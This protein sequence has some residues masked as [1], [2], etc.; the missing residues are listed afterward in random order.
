MVY[1]VTHKLVHVMERDV[2]LTNTTSID[3]NQRFIQ[4][5][6]YIQSQSAD[7]YEPCLTKYYF[8]YR[9]NEVS[10]TGNTN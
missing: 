3:T 9:V 2:S 10:A 8:I 7:T 5:P 4:S 6:L 1:N